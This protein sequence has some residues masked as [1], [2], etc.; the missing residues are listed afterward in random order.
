[1][2]L[3][4]K[5]LKGFACNISFKHEDNKKKIV[6]LK[7]YLSYLE[8]LMQKKYFITK[9]SQGNDMRSLINLL[10]LLFKICFGTCSSPEFRANIGLFKPRTCFKVTFK[11]YLHFTIWVRCQQ[12]IP[13]Q[14]HNLPLIINLDFFYTS[15]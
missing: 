4:G 13:F 2:K 14:V 11:E 10:T 12:H 3:V 9:R 8:V 5:K 7:C 6:D 1:M 15:C